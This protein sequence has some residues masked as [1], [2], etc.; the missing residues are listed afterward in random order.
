[1]C[2]PWYE[3]YGIAKNSTDDIDLGL[4]GMDNGGRNSK[5]GVS[6]RTRQLPETLAHALVNLVLHN[7]LSTGHENSHN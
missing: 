1:M 5:S 2:A 7:T 3:S 6:G 4:L